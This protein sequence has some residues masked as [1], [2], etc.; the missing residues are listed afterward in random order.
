MAKDRSSRRSRD[1]K[2]KSRDRKRSKR[3][4]SDTET[5][6]DGSDDAGE[7]KMTE[8]LAKKAQKMVSFLLI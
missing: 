6:S 5:E 3:S 1:K 7:D 2:S 4:P 8:Y